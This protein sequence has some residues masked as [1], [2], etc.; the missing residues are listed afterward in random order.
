MKPK[1]YNRLW[2]AWMPVLI[3]TACSMAAPSPMPTASSETIA[4]LAAATLQ[5]LQALTPSPTPTLTPTPTPLP[6]TVLPPTFPPLLPTLAMPPATRIPLPAGAT[7]GEVGA[8]IQPG[9]VQ[10]YVLRA[11][12]GQPMLVQVLSP[13]NEVTLSVRTQGGTF[14]LNP[15]ARQSA[16]QGLLPVTED[17]YLSIYGGSTATYFTLSVE[18][19]QRLQFRQGKDSIALVGKT[20]D[21]YRVA[22]VLFALE[23]QRMSVSLNGVAGNAVLAVD[24][25][26]DGRSYLDPTAQRTTFS[27]RLSSSQDYIIQVVPR[28]GKEVKYTLVVGVK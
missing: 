6:P 11:L 24:G 9:E 14:L 12:Q 16:W 2:V 23:D 18:I 26:S 10:P 17:Y 19:P 25:F 7:T 5:A 3:M 13:S 20:R 27:M 15:A 21:G 1:P 4:A 8:W 28:A 22:Y